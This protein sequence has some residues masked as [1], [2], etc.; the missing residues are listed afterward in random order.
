MR[1]AP[2][3]ER[4]AAAACF[5]MIMGKHHITRSDIEQNIAAFTERLRHE[6]DVEKRHILNELLVQEQEKLRA[7]DDGAA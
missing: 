3:T 7:F 4:G 1:S 6:G 2:H 5:L